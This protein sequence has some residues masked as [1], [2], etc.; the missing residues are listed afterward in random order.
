[1]VGGS[2]K[3]HKENVSENLKDLEKSVRRSL[4]GLKEFVS[5]GLKERQENITGS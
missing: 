3:G 5:K 1:M 4:K 2:W